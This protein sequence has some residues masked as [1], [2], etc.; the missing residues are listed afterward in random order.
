M[1]QRDK[2]Q[3]V[4]GSAA[5]PGSHFI[6]RERFDTRKA[7][8]QTKAAAPEHAAAQDVQINEF[9]S[10][11]PKSQVRFFPARPLSLAD[12]ALSS[13]GECAWPRAGA[14]PELESSV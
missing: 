7:K 10:S 9:C 11:V 4:C 1:L 13:S 14:E 5:E 3:G 12:A 6:D 2:K 8:K